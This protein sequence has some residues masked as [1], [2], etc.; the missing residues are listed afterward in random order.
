MYEIRQRHAIKKS[1]G[2]II[3]LCIKLNTEV[4]ELRKNITLSKPQRQAKM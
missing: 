1:V 3:N 2:D 4:E